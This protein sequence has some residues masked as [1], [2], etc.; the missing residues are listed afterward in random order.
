MAAP[1]LILGLFAFGIK[2]GLMPFH[3]WLPEAHAAAPSHISAVLSGVVLKMG[4]YGLIRVMTLAPLE[5]WFGLALLCAGILSGI[6]GV[7][8]A[9][10]QHDLKRL[11]AYHSIENIGIIFI[12]L[13]A[14]VLGLHET[15][16]PLAFAGA[17]LHVWNHAFFKALLFFAAG[18]V[19]HATGTRSI[20]QLGGL[21]PKLR[22]AGL[23]FLI[24]AVA[25]CGLPPLNG[26]VSEWLIYIAGFQA[27]V[28]GS[29]ISASA[30][31]LAVPALALIGALAIACFVKAFS[32]VFLGSPRTDCARQA[33]GEKRSMQIAM[34]ALQSSARNTAVKLK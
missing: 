17:A 29:H 28:P 10:A 5:R 25:I 18:S 3:V 1:V 31:I 13:G 33:H 4:V 34:A 2:A 26:F 24:G 9:L 22:T 6:L 12:G 19:V 27:V 7:I 23:S 16:G 11:L 14:G 20:D 32:V 30:A 15:W 21:L 8:F